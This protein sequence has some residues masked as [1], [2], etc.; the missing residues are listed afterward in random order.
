MFKK[1]SFLFLLFFTYPSFADYTLNLL[2]TND[3]HAHLMPFKQ[4]GEDCS[5]LNNTCRGG[6]DKIKAF[7]DTERKKNPSLILLDAGDR[8]SG[9]IFYTMR[10]SQDIATLM[11]KMNYDAMALGN[12]D[13]DDGLPE[14]IKFTQT[15]TPPLL[16]SNVIFPSNHPLTKK[17]LPALVLHRNG[18]QIGIIG[19]L[20]PETK[21]TSSHAEEISLEEPIDKIRPLIEKLKQQGVNI[22]ILLNHLGFDKDELLAQQL[23]DIDIIVSGHTHTLLSNSSDENAQGPYPVI[24][25]NPQNKPVLIVSAGI[26]GHH[27]GRLSVTFDE[28]GEIVSFNGD[29]IPMDEKI[30]PDNEIKTTIEKLNQ[31][32]SATLLAPI[33]QTV[34]HIAM[35]PRGNFCSE[36][37]YVGEVLA[38]TLLQAANKQKQTDFAFL[39]AGGIRSGLPEGKITSKHL[40]QAYPFDSEAAIIRLTGQEVINY[41]NHGLEKYLINDRTN[42]FLQVAGLSYTFS[43]KT[44]Q[45]QDVLINQKPIELTAIYNVV[46]PVFLAKGGDGF[47]QAKTIDILK[48]N[49]VRD[50][51]ASQLKETGELTQPF[52]N[53]IKCID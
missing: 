20:A 28:T 17:V 21:T 23:T 45:V 3:L 5:E 36:S 41:L 49:T 19:S 37:C 44:Q 11:Q 18:K 52:E 47:P 24:V 39:N 40:A 12:H 31:K 50:L 51:I 35:T 1:M 2:H 7:I 4:N 8:F 6:F 13:F 9:T 29:T 22:I 46:L 53:K 32:L 43:Q 38:Q 10:K 15:V 30:L 14:L 34:T 42:E 27:V 48:G 33:C 26:G 25:Q 16:A